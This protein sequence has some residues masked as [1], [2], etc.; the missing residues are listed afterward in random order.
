MILDAA[1][2]RMGVMNLPLVRRDHQAVCGRGVEVQGADQ[3]NL[4]K[5][6]AGSVLTVR[7]PGFRRT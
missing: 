4:S 3:V 7:L 6:T 2:Q 5:T 1:V